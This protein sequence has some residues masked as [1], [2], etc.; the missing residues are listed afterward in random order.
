MLAAALV[1]A[2]SMSTA[3]ARPCA[4][5]VERIRAGA[6]DLVALGPRPDSTEAATR[7]AD[8][9]EAAL[10]EM[11]ATPR[12]AVIGAIDVPEIRVGGWTVREGGIRRSTSRNVWV[13]FGGPG[14]ARLLLAHYDTVGGSPGAVDNAAAAGVLLELA[15]CL[16]D[17]PP[18]TPVILGFTGAEEIG[19]L[20]ARAMLRDGSLGELALVVSLDLLGHERQLAINGVSELWG[21]RRL[22]W[23]ADRVSASGADVELP[24]IHRLVSR[25]FP[26]LER[27]DHGA[28]SAAGIPALH[29]YG[30]GR[31]RIYLG[32]H[33][34][35]DTADTIDDAALANAF[36]LSAELAYSPERLPAAGDDLGMWIDRPGGVTVAPAIA[37]VA[38]EG[39]LV[40]ATLMLLFGA[41]IRR[42]REARAG[43]VGVLAVIGLYAVAWGAATGALLI[44]Q[45]VRGEPLVVFLDLPRFVIASA[46]IAVAVFGLLLLAATRRWS[47]AI[48]SRYHATAAGLE[49]VA[50]AGLL[51]FGAFELAWLPLFCAA[52]FALGGLFIHR[53]LVG[54]VITTAAA[55]V[56][57]MPLD[58]GLLREAVF[59]GFY[60][61]ELPAS[62]VLAAVA[63][64]PHLALCGA[65]R[66]VLTGPR[67]RR[68]VVA[69]AVSLAILLLVGLALLL[70][71]GA[72]CS[73]EAIDLYGYACELAP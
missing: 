59:H 31:P 12:A 71:P 32:Y 26:Q 46:G 39:A 51:G 4:G 11:G 18:P 70:V 2:A 55:V 56:A 1:A 48:G 29:L 72:P 44:E 53:P 21:Q 20:G 41:F 5:E 65:L 23:L 58:P 3:E 37:A 19:L 13:R 49:L 27:S 22:E 8:R 61:T 45:L 35:L 40:G 16:A 36:D 62:A 38:I 24:P 33:S 67:D 52:L 66:A 15:R 63:L 68:A 47:L 14:P 69:A 43:G 57:L 17:E 42:R 54:L 73:P 25:R 60:P 6:E 34:P 28:F 10:R 9:I 50:G 7:A 64:P 30:R